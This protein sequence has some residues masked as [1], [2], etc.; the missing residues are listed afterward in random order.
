MKNKIETNSLTWK[1]SKI[2]G[3]LTKQLIEHKNGSLK[4]IKVEPSSSYP[5]HNHPEK[6]EFI[7]VLEGSP[8]IIIGKDHYYGQ[9]AEFFILSEKMNHSII[10]NDSSDCILLVGAINS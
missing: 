8:E 9:R 6:V 10:N 5:L 3:F 1:E 4:L 7:Y 2:K